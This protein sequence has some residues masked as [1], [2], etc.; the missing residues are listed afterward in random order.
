MVSRLNQ[1]LAGDRRTILANS[2]F[3]VATTIATAGLG[4]AYWWL[5]ARTFPAQQVGIAA[6]AVSGMTLLGYLAMLGFGTL[7]IAV[8]H[9]NGD[10][11]IAYVATASLTSAVVGGLLGVLALLVAPVISPELAGFARDPAGQVL[12]PVGVGLTASTLV[13]DTALIGLLRGG[14]QFVRNLVFAGGKLALLLVAVVFIAT[15]SGVTIFATW[16]A[17]LLVSML[18]LAGLALRVE[19][20]LARYRPDTQILRHLS[21][22]LLKHHALNLA[23]QAPTLALPLVVATALSVTSAAYFYAAWMMAG[24]A[25]IAS[26][27]LGITLYAVSSRSPSR[28]AHSM[29]LTLG[30]SLLVACA[31]GLT[32]V[33]GGRTLLGIFGP[34]YATEASTA[35]I[36]LTLATLPGIVKTHFL[37]V[38]RLADRIGIGAAIMAAGAVLELAMAAVGG[39]SSGLVGLS[40]G[41]AA[42]VV[43]EALVMSPSVLRAAGFLGR[44]YLPVAVRP[45]D[46]DPSTP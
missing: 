39:E 11:A 2:A 26:P 19:G 30:L 3:L 36:F 17:G 40:Q 43:I 45:D 33:V 15:A 32:V 20:R 37:Q 34:A 41:Y 23:V 21:R 7:L 25:A 18:V 9:E 14:T 38:V 22:G 29:R 12:F 1:F 4:F 44:P 8:F 27:S 10:R 5:A 16:V 28:L 42:A 46:G 6:A 35:L 31:A 24:F 13:V